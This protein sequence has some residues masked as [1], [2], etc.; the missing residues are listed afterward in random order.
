MTVNDV[1]YAYK[2]SAYKLSF[3]NLDELKIEGIKIDFLNLEALVND[4][5]KP[6]TFTLITF[7]YRKQVCL[8][9]CAQAET[10]RSAN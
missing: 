10:L 2:D 9:R 8:S 4:D 5:Q 3:H 6:H 1:I 7:N